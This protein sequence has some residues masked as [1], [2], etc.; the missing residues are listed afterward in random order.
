VAAPLPSGD[1][2]GVLL[3]WENAGDAVTA[4]VSNDTQANSFN[5][6]TRYLNFISHWPKGGR[7]GSGLP[8]L[9]HGRTCLSPS[10]WMRLHSADAATEADAC[11]VRCSERTSRA[12]QRDRAACRANGDVVSRGVQTGRN[13]PGSHPLRH[14][15]LR[16]RSACR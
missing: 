6:T 7:R 10:R 3:V 9:T 1:G 15:T 5:G 12:A 11:A 2:W 13:W 14:A 4:R 16:M 8:L